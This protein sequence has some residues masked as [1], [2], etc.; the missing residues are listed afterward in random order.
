[1]LSRLFLIKQGKC[2]GHG[3]MLC[4]YEKKHSGKCTK[5]R[6]DVLKALEKWELEELKNL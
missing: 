5:I 2:C 1:M 6:K 4:P 3:C